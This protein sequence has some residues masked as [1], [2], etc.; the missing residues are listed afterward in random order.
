[1]NQKCKDSTSSQSLASSTKPL[2]IVSDSETK[3]VAVEHRYTRAVKREEGKP[4]WVRIFNSRMVQFGK[5]S[6]ETR[7]CKELTE[8]C[9][10]FCTRLGPREKIRSLQGLLESTQKNWLSHAFFRDSALCI[11]IKML[12]FF[13]KKKERIFLHRFPQNSSLHK[14]NPREHIKN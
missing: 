3:M 5:I 8:G 11:S 4:T 1:M 10:S 9:T 12:T 13:L 7:K 6:P 14:E 2:R